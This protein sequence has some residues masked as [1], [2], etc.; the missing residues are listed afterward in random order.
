MT[1]FIGGL[2]VS[3]D[4]IHD[5]NGTPPFQVIPATT[6]RKALKHI[7]DQLFTENALTYSPELLNV[8]IPER[9]WDLRDDIWERERID[10]PI[11]DMILDIQ[12][13]A[14]NRLYSTKTLHRLLD[15]ELK[16]TSE[17]SPFTIYELFNTLTT[18]IWSE[19]N[20]YDNVSSTRR[21]LQR[22]HASIL[23]NMITDPSEKMPQEAAALAR[24]DIVELKTHIKKVLKKKKN[25][26]PTKAHY[27]HIVA[28]IGLQL[29][30]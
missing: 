8:L 2:E 5:K 19:L 18:T 10:I 23:L 4:H 15:N 25:N 12:S 29:E 3:R 24:Y 13:V 22:L 28:H 20:T 7:S 14:L 26:I 1:R 11:H 6:Q 30:N 16:I 21:N 27:E 17:N 9:L